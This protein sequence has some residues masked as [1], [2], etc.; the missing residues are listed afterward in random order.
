MVYLTVILPIRNEESVIYSTLQAL[1]DQVYPKDRYE[2]IVVDGRSTDGTH[3]IVEKFIREHTDVNVRLLDNPG[4]L[5][6]R[7]RNIG[8]RVAKGRLIAVIDGHVHIPHK[9]LYANMEWL[10]ER[11]HALCLAHPTPPLLSGSEAGNSNWIAAARTSRLGHSQHS[12]IYSDYEGWCDPVTSGFAYDRSLFDQVGYFDEAFDAAED[13]EF[14]YRLKQAGVRAYASPTMI[15]Y[16]YPRKTLRALYR[17]MVRYGVGRSRFVRKHPSAFSKETLIPVAVL[18]LSSLLPLAI[19]VPWGRPIIPLVYLTIFGM[20][21]AVL[22]IAGIRVAV[23]T[24]RVFPGFFV[25][26]ALWV[27]HLGLG[28]GFLSS[29]FLPRRTLLS[30]HKRPWNRRYPAASGRQAVIRA[31]SVERDTPDYA[32]TA[33]NPAVVEGHRKGPN[34]PVSDRPATSVQSRS[35]RSLN[36]RQQP[37]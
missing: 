4:K 31:S 10:K 19:A 9:Q 35:D 7:A 34:E 1:S 22:G 29:V 33:G 16:Y 6:S 2:L 24:N 11:H 36:A 28:W 32:I 3:G 14:N 15:I 20:Y 5:S 23:N 12:Y 30:D 25:P 17:Q 27:I 13:V 8:I 37:T 26:V 18:L 21:W